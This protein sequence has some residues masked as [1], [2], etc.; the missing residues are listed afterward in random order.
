MCH[1][2][3][4]KAQFCLLIWFQASIQVRETQV[5][6][7]WAS[8]ARQLVLLTEEENKK[9]DKKEFVALRRQLEE[10]QQ[11][12]LVGNLSFDCLACIINQ[13][14]R[15][16]AIARHRKLKAATEH[17]ILTGIQCERRITAREM[18]ETHLSRRADIQATLKEGG[19]LL[20]RLGGMKMLE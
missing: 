6:K 9:K 5:L 8:E 3:G 1:A 12:M 16:K 14:E 11:K 13:K 10:Q 19:Q 17:G 20:E 18:Q 2:M 4:S 7:V 15:R